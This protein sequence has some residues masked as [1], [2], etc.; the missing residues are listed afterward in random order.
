MAH[1][2]LSD[3]VPNTDG[4]GGTWSVACAE[5][6]WNYSGTYARTNTVAEAVALRLAN[7][8]GRL[9]EKDPGSAAV[10]GLGEPGKSDHSPE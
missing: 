9:H 8:Y 6:N 5:C 1:S 7:A 2:T 10:K 4:P 3:T